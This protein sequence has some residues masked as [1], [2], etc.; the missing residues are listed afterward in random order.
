MRAA[1]RTGGLELVQEAAQRRYGCSGV[2]GAERA[3]DGLC[4]LVVRGASEA[5]QRLEQARRRLGVHE[6]AERLGGRG[7]HGAV[8][9][10]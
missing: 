2:D 3:E 7:H 5:A 9:I 10:P 6:L 8:G 1:S 4:G